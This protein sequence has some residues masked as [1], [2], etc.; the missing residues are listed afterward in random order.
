M[1]KSLF[2]I[3]R[4]QF[5]VIVII[6]TILGLILASGFVGGTILTFH[7]FQRQ[8]VDFNS[9]PPIV[10]IY[11]LLSI[12]FP[13]VFIVYY[14]ARHT[15]NKSAI[16]ILRVLFVLSFPLI[17]YGWAIVLPEMSVSDFF[18]VITFLLLHIAV[19]LRFPS[20]LKE[21]MAEKRT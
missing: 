13:S 8:G 10:F 20:Y 2:V 9:Y 17:I 11:L 3:T 4:S 14:V 15:F 18:W 21:L 12:V 16:I 7:N 1:Q 5:K 6:W 19:F